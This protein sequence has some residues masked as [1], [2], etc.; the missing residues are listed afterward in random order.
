MESRDFRDG[1]LR[2]LLELAQ[3]L[4]R[5][6]PAS[7]SCTFG[8][9]AFWSAN[10]PHGE[11]RVHLWY[12]GDELAG[13]GWVTGDTEL[14]WQVRPERPELLDE[15]LD[16]AQPDEVLVRADHDDATRRLRAHGLAHDPGG[17]WIRINQR[18]LEEIEE[19][20]L[21][22][23][24]RVRTVDDGDFESRA[25]AHRS[26][27]HPSRFRDEVYANVRASWPY[28]QDL[29]CVVEAPDGSIAA[30]AL[31]W[32]DE[33]NAIGELEPVGTHADHQQRGLGRAVN[34][35]AL[36]RLREEG[37][38]LALVACRGDDAYPI[39]CRL[40]ESV[41]FREQSRTLPFRRP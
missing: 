24:Y 27:F 1:D 40:Y 21:P 19:P 3:E 41:G 12:E 10:I 13:W 35:F 22:E 17:A 26:A 9:I 39:P 34:L 6:D 20:S 4:W 18:G 33:V 36:Q 7:L 32:L 16:W 30:Y 25:A 15:I 2:P 38:T 31:A 29:D 37:A 14:E 8:Q 28:R 11:H 5:A 23:G